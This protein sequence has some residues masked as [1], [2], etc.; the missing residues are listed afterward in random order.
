MLFAPQVLFE[1]VD[2]NTWKAGRAAASCLLLLS[3]PC[4]D[5][6]FQTLEGDR[7]YLFSGHS[8]CPELGSAQ[9]PKTCPPP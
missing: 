4:I 6:T 3:L 2:G 5:Q 9:D 1:A 8:H 7:E